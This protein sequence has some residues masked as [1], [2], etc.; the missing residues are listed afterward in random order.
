LI[1]DEEYASRSAR[2][3]R[4]ALDAS[5]GPRTATDVERWIDI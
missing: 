5:H 3:A 1:E 2:L 4:A